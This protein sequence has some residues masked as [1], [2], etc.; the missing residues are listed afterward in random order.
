MARKVARMAAV[1]WADHSK[2]VKEEVPKYVVL[3]HNLI[4]SI[5][6]P[7]LSSYETT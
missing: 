6:I 2:A 7:P 1:S 5:D 4:W 3:T